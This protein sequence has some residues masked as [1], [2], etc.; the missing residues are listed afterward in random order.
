MIA[1]ADILNAKIL[2]VDDK[3]AN[4][5]L[6]EGMLRIAGYTSVHST[7]NPNEVCDLHIAN[8]YGLILLDLQMAMLPANEDPG[9]SQSRSACG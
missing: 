3:E 8:H 2:V 4:V 9:G 6:I 1:L 7:M 5:R